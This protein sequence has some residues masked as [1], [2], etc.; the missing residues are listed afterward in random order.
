MS[1][2][3]RGSGPRL[4]PVI[5]DVVSRALGGPRIDVW[6]PLRQRLRN[7]LAVELQELRREAAVP[8]SFSTIRVLDVALWMR[9]R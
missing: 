7:G 9:H 1:A 4:F 3:S 6:E 2:P 8:E 5:D